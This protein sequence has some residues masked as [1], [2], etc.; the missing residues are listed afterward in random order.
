MTNRP[1]LVALAALGLTLVACDLSPRG[2][3]EA[4]V[5]VA[6]DARRVDAQTP[7]RGVEL[8]ED[9]QT[10][11]RIAGAE[12]AIRPPAPGG[13]AGGALPAVTS[14][15]SWGATGRIPPIEGPATP[16]RP[17]L[18]APQGRRPG[19]RWAPL[20]PWSGRRTGVVHRRRTCEARGARPRAEERNGGEPA[21]G[22]G[23]PGIRALTHPAMPQRSISESMTVLL[24]G[25]VH[26]IN[27][28]D[29]V[30]VTPLGPEFAASLGIPASHVG[31]IAGSY[32]ASACV[33]G[34]LGAFVLDRFDRRA[35][36]AVAM[37]GLVAG[38]AAGGL[39]TGLGSLVATRVVAGFFGGPATS[40]GYAIIADC[41]PAERRGR[42]LGALMGALSL[43]SIV[44]IPAG[45]ELARAAGWRAPFL[46]LG[47]LG[48]PV[49]LGV[50]FALPPLR[51]HLEGGPPKAAGIGELFANGTVRWSY[52]MSALSMLS[53]FMVVPNVPTFFEFNLGYPH[54]RL[55]QL[56]LAGGL[57]SLISMRAVGSLVDRFG[58][59]LTGSVGALAYVAGVWAAFVASPP[60]LPVVVIFVTM[61]VAGAFRNVSANALTSKVPGPL[62]R[63]RF[64]SVQSA[65]Q[66]AASAAGGFLSTRL[67]SEQADHRLVG[68]GRVALFASLLAGALVPLL[69]LVDRRVRARLS[70]SHGVSPDSLPNPH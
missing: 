61:M 21:G 65:V 43:A 24:V 13:P 45:L 37:L 16:V 51:R 36:L 70:A 46:A 28:L 55:S 19:A 63:A 27:V 3:K 48:V 31:V 11:G 40:I 52:A 12:R 14:W 5:S 26:F 57:A 58:S 54:E 42:A 23:A 62:E 8:Q 39:A 4:A 29:F 41:I 64:M 30:M 10:S 69:W 34:L 35:A 59:A 17:R 18:S 67:L 50:A 1:W 9:H 25:A 68:M 7:D 53:L 47:A 2:P 56:Y 66:H 20:K 60:P 44:G 15:P 22:L 32:T 38:T 33:S 6:G 49:T